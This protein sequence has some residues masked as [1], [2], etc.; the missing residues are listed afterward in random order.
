M[1]LERMGCWGLVMKTMVENLEYF[2]VSRETTGLSQAEKN[3]TFWLRV[4]VLVGYG[5]KYSM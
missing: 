2:L 1:N 5:V 3:A 4:Q